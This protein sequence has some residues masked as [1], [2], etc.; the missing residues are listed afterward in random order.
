MSPTS[1][2]S[3]PCQG[4]CGLGTDFA[5]VPWIMVLMH[6]IDASACLVCNPNMRGKWGFSRGCPYPFIHRYCLV[7]GS[8]L[9]LILGESIVNCTCVFTACGDDGRHCHPVNVTHVCV[10]VTATVMQQLKGLP[11]RYAIQSDLFINEW[12]ESHCLVL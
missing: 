6:F 9:A 10:S 3:I 1:R 11:R 12:I 8:L 5:G 4:R 2:A 7:T